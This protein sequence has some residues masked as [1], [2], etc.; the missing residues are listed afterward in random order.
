MR[1]Y[2]KDYS[3]FPNLRDRQLMCVFVAQIAPR[4]CYN[5]SAHR[6][7][8][9]LVNDM[10]LRNSGSRK[11]WVTNRNAIFGFDNV[12]RCSQE[13]NSCASMCSGRGVESRARILHGLA[14]FPEPSIGT[15]MILCPAA[16]VIGTI[17]AGSTA[18]L[19]YSSVHPSFSFILEKYELCLLWWRLFSL[20]E[21]QDR[22]P[23]CEIFR[24]TTYTLDIEF[25]FHS[26]IPY[27]FSRTTVPENWGLGLV[28]I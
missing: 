25:K 22:E 28:C 10:T 21:T 7:K 11:A 27:V 16:G 1:R 2:L 24:G 4:L 14:V 19:S 9:I 8:R 13:G 17:Y 15:D 23:V 5:F 12:R 3:A 18:H 20:L 6:T 26:L